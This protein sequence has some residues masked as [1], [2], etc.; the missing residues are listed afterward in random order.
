MRKIVFIF[1]LA[2]SI[3][4]TSCSAKVDMTDKSLETEIQITKHPKVA[5]YD[6]GKLDELSS[7]D[8]DL[9][10]LWQL[11]LRSTDLSNLDIEDRI[12][13]LMYADFDSKTKWPEKLPKDFDID[14]IIEFGKNPG[15]QVNELHKKGITGKGIGIAIID[16][17][18]LVDHVEYKDNLKFYEEIHKV[19]EEAEMHG[20][21]VASIAVGK[22]VGV[23]PEA[24]LYYIAAPN[25]EIKNN[26]TELNFTWLAQAINR[27]LEI[28]ELL[29]EENKI[30]VISI[31]VAWHEG[32]EGYTEVMEAVKEAKKQG[33]FVVSAGLQETYNGYF[34]GHLG[35][36]P[37]SNPNEFSSY[38]PNLH[39]AKGFY[40]GSLRLPQ[41][42]LLMPSD[43]RVT[44]SP[45]G[46]EDYA[47]Y[48]Q[49]GVSWSIPYMAGLYALACQVN[50]DITPAT[51][52]SKALRTG[53]T[54]TLQKNDKQYKLGNIISPLELVTDLE[55]KM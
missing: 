41:D 48:R 17:V 32:E 18:L 34:I 42:V 38:E 36:S 19:S 23:A 21:A 35:R 10:L 1:I 14:K 31:S 54:I 20:P 8:W 9:D 33:I 13:D 15:L 11:D 47:F 51:F 37:L 2:L 5:N 3:I 16:Q 55:S 29:P 49:G 39:I 24:D 50:P 30:R 7:L 27:V 53:K 45:T 6:R 25:S 40:D 28:N 26:I 12:N 43:S 52:L 22:S 46:I 44:A 4:M